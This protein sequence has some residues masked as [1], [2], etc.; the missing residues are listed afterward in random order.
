MSL[1]LIVTLLLSSWGNH[2]PSKDCSCIP[3]APGENTHYGGNEIVEYREEKILKSVHGVTQDQ[4]GDVMEGVLVE[5]FT[6]STRQ[7]I[8]ACKTG[9]DGKF[10]F[11]N[12][13]AGDY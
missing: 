11:K 1:M 3:P 12:I 7:R 10:C 9:K 6:P 13:P 5:I 8:F 2:D 4:N